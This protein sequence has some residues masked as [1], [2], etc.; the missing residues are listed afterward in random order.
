MAAL[1]VP[2]GP[3]GLAWHTDLDAARKEAAA[4]GRPILSLRLLGRLDE[5]LSCANS[6]FFRSVLYADP[7]VAA[8]LRDRFVLHWSSERPVPV[9]TVDFG[10]GRRLRRTL[11]GNSVHYVLDAAGRPV[12]AVP[13]LYS[14]AAFLRTLKAAEE[15]HRACGNADARDACL[16]RRHAARLAALEQAWVRDV[17][18]VG[19]AGTMP[20]W[21]AGEER[22]SGA[23]AADGRAYAKS[24]AERPLLRAVLGTRPEARPREDEP[25]RRLADLPAAGGSLGAAARG[26]MAAEGATLGDA[27]RFERAAAV[28]TVRNEYALHSRINRWFAEGEVSDFERLNE[29]VYRELFLTPRSDPWLGLAPADAYAALPRGGLEQ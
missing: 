1:A 15:T 6:R 9:V 19:L 7:V 23:L 17:A 2:A 4:T 16:R 18:A 21:R 22:S 12:D 20:P 24:L 11:T 3:P 25:W 29:R 5:P 13:G 28:D 26:R 14:P 27:V 8:A 10:D